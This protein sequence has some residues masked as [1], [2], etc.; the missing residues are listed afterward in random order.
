VLDARSKLTE[1]Q[2]N[3]VKAR[4]DYATAWARYRRSTGTLLT[5]HDI[6]VESNLAPRQPA[7]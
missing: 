3:E 7:R 1:A 2:S 6:L 4:V 5:H